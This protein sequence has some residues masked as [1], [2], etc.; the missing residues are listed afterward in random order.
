MTDLHAEKSKAREQ[1]K[2]KKDEEEKQKQIDAR[3]KVLC[4]QNYKEWCQKKQR[5]RKTLEKKAREEEARKERIKKEY[6][7]SKKKQRIKRKRE[8]AQS[9]VTSPVQS[10]GL[11]KTRS[12]DRRKKRPNYVVTGLEHRPSKPEE[13]EEKKETEEEP[14]SIFARGSERLMTD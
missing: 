4:T 10:P 8:R 12:P 11:P 14:E 2:R 9:A 7:A 6:W 1:R 5:E 3:N 13:E